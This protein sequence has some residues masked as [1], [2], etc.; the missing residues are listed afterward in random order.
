MCY[1]SY[2][3]IKVNFLFLLDIEYFDGKLKYKHEEFNRILSDI[4]E[5]RDLNLPNFEQMEELDND[6]YLEEPINDGSDPFKTI[7]HSVE[8]KAKQRQEEYE[9]A[10][11]SSYLRNHGLK[12]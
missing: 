10:R 4:R 7:Q 11:A 8:E 6:L 1:I 2:R 5:L 3:F 9:R 12:V